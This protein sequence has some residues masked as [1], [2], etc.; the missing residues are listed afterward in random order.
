MKKIF[1]IISWLSI[2]TILLLLV[3]PNKTTSCFLY[4]P[5]PPPAPAQQQQHEEQQPV[6]SRPDERPY[7]ED[8]ANRG[9]SYRHNCGR[10]CLPHCL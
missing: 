8:I 10:L 1:I 7:N 9:V 2:C 5:P 4:C 3:L 6:N